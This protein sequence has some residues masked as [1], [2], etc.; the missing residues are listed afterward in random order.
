MKPISAGSDNAAAHTAI[1]PTRST[2]ATRWNAAAS[3]SP[4]SSTPSTQFREWPFCII[5]TNSS[6]LPSSGRPSTYSNRETRSAVP[7]PSKS[8]AP[9]LDAQTLQYAAAGLRKTQYDRP[10]RSDFESV[11]NGRVDGS[12]QPL[13]G[14]YRQDRPFNE[15]MES[16]KTRETLH[17]SPSGARDSMPLGD[18]YRYSDTLKYETSGRPVQSTY[19]SSSYKQYSSSYQ[20]QN[21]SVSARDSPY[22]SDP[23]A[24]IRAYATQ[25][26]AYTLMEP[27]RHTQN[28]HQKYA[29]SSTNSPRKSDEEGTKFARELRDQ[30][31]TRSQRIANQ[32]QQSQLRDVPAPPSLDSLYRQSR[33]QGGDQID[34]LIRDMEWKMNTGV[35]AAGDSM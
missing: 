2:T 18:I 29:Y 13:S 10:L 33:R 24:A 19:S 11:P 31:L 9:G 5:Q 32:F 35:G 1:F 14:R 25:T 6:F 7:P 26:P 34:S 12:N 20:Q 21:S 22:I 17:A 4:S 16:D 30:G 8:P 3:P 28:Y 15:W 23:R 27:Q